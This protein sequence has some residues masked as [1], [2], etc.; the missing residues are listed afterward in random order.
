LVNIIFYET[1]MA[2]MPKISVIVGT[3]PEAIKLAPFLLELNNCNLIKT[4]LITT[5]QH[6]EIVEEIIDL[7]N[8][9]VHKNLSVMKEG[10][11]LNELTCEIIS[12]L[13]KDFKTHRPDLVIVQ[14]DTATAFAAALASFYEKIPVGHIEA[15]LRTDDILSPFPEEANRRLISQISKL[16]FAPTERA[17]ENLERSQVCG[18]IFLTGNTVIDALLTVAKKE[19]PLPFKGINWD[20]KVILATV[21]RRENWGNKLINIIEGFKKILETHI[22]TTF[23]IPMHPNKIVR[24]PFIKTLESHPRVLLID[25]LRYD[26][27]VSVIKK[28]YLLLTDS[29]GIQEEAPSLGK[30]VLVLRNTTEREEAIDAGTAILVGTNKEDIFN[31]THRLLTNQSEYN[32]MSKSVNPFGD[33]KASKRI[34]Q[35]CLSELSINE[36]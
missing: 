36:K 7:F 2:V 35:A 31:E 10:Q 14:G 18:K 12:C 26:E 21:H 17:K 29:G 16:H 3:R 24:E 13:Q 28:C 34:L 5:G 6:K 32:K 15:G 1:F 20:Q 23:I 33:G 4:R 19:V 27:L 22:D 11:S 8:L 9:K 30:P 25:P